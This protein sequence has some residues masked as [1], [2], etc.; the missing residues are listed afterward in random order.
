MVRA[1]LVGARLPARGLLERLP[2]FAVESVRRLD[3]PVDAHD[4]LGRFQQ[5]LILLPYGCWSFCVGAHGRWLPARAVRG[6]GVGLG[7]GF[8]HPRAAGAWLL[9][10][11][12]CGLWRGVESA[13]SCP[14][15]AAPSSEGCLPLPRDV[16]LSTGPR[17]A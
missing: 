2:V 15:R 16:P 3:A 6:L 13:S 12:C 14:A 10:R 17:E 9:V 5:L 8:G 11:L 1:L 4:G 7:A